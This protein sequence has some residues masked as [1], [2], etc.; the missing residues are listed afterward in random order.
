MK[1]TIEILRA[2]QKQLA[3]IPRQEQT[4]IIDAVKRLSHDPRPPGSR[5]LTGRSA[6]RIRIGSYRVLYEIH[7]G[8]LA[9]LVVTIGHRREVYR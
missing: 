2:A 7:D 8:H 3:K 6:H 5:K 9:I 1:Y 4:R